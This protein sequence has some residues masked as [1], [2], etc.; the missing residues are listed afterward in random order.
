MDDKQIHKLE[1]IVT[2]L[3]GDVEHIK[4]RIDNGM[5]VTITKIFERIETLND[6]ILKDIMPAIND[7]KK[8]I[9]YI[10][11]GCITI[12]VVGVLMTLVK[13]GFGMIFN[14]GK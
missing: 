4:G 1:L 9:G 6:L 13:Y 5:S 8:W 11:K 14:G 12:I 3:K 7:S 2:A 10:Q